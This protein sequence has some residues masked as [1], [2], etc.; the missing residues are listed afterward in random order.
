[1]FAFSI[2][3]NNKKQLFCARDRFGIKP[4]YYYSDDEKFV[5]GS[6][7][8]AV[9]AANNIDKTLSYDAIN[10]FFAY[11]YIT[12]NHSIY[13]KIK[14]LQPSHYLLLSFEGKPTI[15]IKKYWEIK[16][17]P[18]HSKTEKQWASEIESSLSEAVKLHMVADVP[19]GAFLSGGIDSSS[20]VSMMARNSDIPVKTFTIGFKEEKYSELKL[21]RAVAQKYGCEHHEQIVE[22]ESISLLPKLVRA[23]DE[24]FADS[25]A[26][27]TYYVSKFAREYVKVVLSGDGGDELFAGYDIYTYLK[28]IYHCSSDS[29]GF[30]RFFWGNINKLIPQKFPGKGFTRL[31]SQNRKHIGAHLSIWPKEERRKLILASHSMDFNNK[32]ESFKEGILNCGNGNDFISNLQNLDLQTYLAD[33][34]LTKVDRASKLSSLE[35]RVPL[36]DHKLAELSFQIPSNLKLNG[37]KQKYIL[38]EAMNHLPDAIL[39]GPKK[40]FS[41]PLSMWFQ[42]D[43]KEYLHDTLLTG[44]PMLEDYLDKNYVKSMIRDSTSGMR[45]FTSRLWSLLCFEEWLKQNR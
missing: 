32:P 26:I 44:N 8:K 7:I 34:I 14:K 16:F 35:V 33:D 31:L 12:S 37:N 11:G 24:P 3:D 1:M 5:F 21:A 36:L 13:D 27:P 10:S 6:E 45:D 9:T 43:L 40:G 15:E 25:S 28:N 22:P 29:P 38:K 2:W 23:Y 30:N 41:L 19:L 39:N 20:V 42:N 4:F 17:K 18:D